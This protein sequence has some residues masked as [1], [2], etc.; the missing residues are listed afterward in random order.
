MRIGIIGCGTIA[1]VMHA[2]YVAELPNAELYALCDPVESRVHALGDRYDVPHRFGSTEP[3]IESVGGELD[4]AIVLTPPHAH[5]DAVIQ[6]L[7]EGIATLV[8]KPLAVSIED[9]ERMT[10]AADSANVTS[11]VAYMKRYDPAFERVQSE[12][13]EID[14]IDLITAYDVDPDHGRI[15][16]EVYDLIEGDLPESVIRK[17]SSKKR[18]DA[19][20]AIGVDD[21]DLA[22][23]YAA[24][25]EHACHD[26]NVLRGLFGDVESI[27][28][29]DLYADGRYATAH[30]QYAGGTHCVLDSG[31][32]DRNWFEE[33]VR[34][35]AADRSVTVEYGNPFIKNTPTEVRVR[36]G[37]EE[38]SETTHIPTYDE[39]F[40]CEIRHFFRAARGEVDVRTPFEEARDDVRLIADLFRSSIDVDTLGTYE[41]GA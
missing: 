2:P 17:S 5:A 15:I 39:S 21:D 22:A 31:F 4:A 30:L 20:S 36:H 37:I 9:A 6:L 38:Y 3:L 29:V 32:S 24:H 1:Q 19:T 12:L 7:E 10:E 27:D 25:L 23:Q 35:D 26:V 28:Y 18:S 40:K 34:V 8:E 33:W 14:D 41:G 16:N 13:A 11:M